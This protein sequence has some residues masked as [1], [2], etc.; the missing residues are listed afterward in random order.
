MKYPRLRLKRTY[1]KEIQ[2]IDEN[3]I[4]NINDVISNMTR[5]INGE[6]KNKAIYL[7]EEYLWVI[8]QDHEGCK[9]LVPLKKK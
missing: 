4:A 3:S 7:S 9:I 5:R 1:E 6:F 8:G 2:E